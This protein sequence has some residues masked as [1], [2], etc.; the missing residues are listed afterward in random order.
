MRTQKHVKIVELMR[1]QRLVNADAAALGAV[2]VQTHQGR[3]KRAPPMQR[4]RWGKAPKNP[5]ATSGVC[6][7]PLSTAKAK[8]SLWEGSSVPAALTARC[9]FD[10]V[11]SEKMSPEEFGE[12]YIVG[13]RPV[14]LRGVATSWIATQKWQKILTLKRAYPQ[15]KFYY[16]RSSSPAGYESMSSY[17]D[18]MTSAEALESTWPRYLW[19]RYPPL[20]PDQLR[21]LSSLIS[22]PHA[23]LQDDA[24][25]Q[26][27]HGETR[28]HPLEDT[29][30]PDF[31]AGMANHTDPSM[32]PSVI[33]AVLS[34]GPACS[35]SHFHRH[36]SAFCVLVG[37]LKWW[38]L[39]DPTSSGRSLH[40]EFGSEEGSASAASYVRGLQEQRGQAWWAGRTAGHLECAQ[41]AGDLMFVPAGREHFILNLWPSAG[42]LIISVYTVPYNYIYIL[43]S[44]YV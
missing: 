29:Q 10:V 2:A 6:F 11:D 18:Y 40:D 15:S 32:R 34:I 9:D 14:L 37:G 5:L 33:A 26:I 24:L 3:I 27:S 22:A 42:H 36:D 4:R 13:Q 12:K 28:P 44:Y 30:V 25:E 21:P 41:K 43:F 20:A 17:L 23:C 19:V 39:N 31:I 35:G 38:I 1:E 8:A 16:E 7:P